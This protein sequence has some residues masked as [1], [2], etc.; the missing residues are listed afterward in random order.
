MKNS[1]KKVVSHY[2]ENNLQTV[3][4][5]ITGNMQQFEKHADAVEQAQ[6]YIDKFGPQLDA[7]GLLSPEN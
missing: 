1:M 6:D 3:T 4:S 2:V 5:I 7:W